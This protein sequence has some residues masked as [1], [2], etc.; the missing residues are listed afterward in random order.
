VP[1]FPVS[2]NFAVFLIPEIDGPFFLYLRVES[3]HIFCREELS[4]SPSERSLHD[5]GESIDEY[6]E[7]FSIVIF[8]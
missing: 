4:L 7:W 2:D 1:R 8:F 5:I 3:L 6:L